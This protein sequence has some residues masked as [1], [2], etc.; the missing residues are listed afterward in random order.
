M[1]YLYALISAAMFGANGSVVK[2]IIEAGLSPAQVTF[3]RS[4]GGAV[5]C[6]LVLLFTDRRS[7]RPGLRTL[8]VLAALGLVGVAGVQ[9][10]YAQAIG[11][12]PVGIALLIE[13]LGVPL[14]A[15]IALVV[16]R[17][18]IKAR[19]WV[20][21]AL[22]LGGLAVVAQ[23]WD[24]TLEP[25][26]VVLAG[27]AALGLAAYFLIG[28]RGVRTATPMAVGFW[29]MATATVFWTIFGGWWQID[30]AVFTS[31]SEVGAGALEVP[32]LGLL[33]FALI[34]GTFLPFVIGYLALKHLGATRGGVLASSEVVFAFA[35]AWL[36]L[37]E[38]LDLTQI[39]GALIVVVGIVLAQTA[40]RGAV[41]DP[42]LVIVSAPRD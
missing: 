36:F 38:S 22:M 40:R 26:G 21:I 24:S 14:V 8:A 39:L 41:V 13:Y 17:E 30:P 4:L 23:V 27:L 29:S 16:F 34:F 18:P 5:L 9:F 35:A 33:A 10:F 25:L 37:G 28:E 15:V 31:T 20:G 19:L 3:F 2:L 32:F 12:L 42:D 1:G 11:R 7:F 6:G